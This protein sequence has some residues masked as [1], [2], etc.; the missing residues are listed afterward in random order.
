MLIMGVM[1]MNEKERFRKAIFEMVKQ[2]KLALI[3]ASIQCGLSYRQVLANLVNQ[4]GQQNV[5]LTF[6]KPNDPN[7]LKVKAAQIGLGLMIMR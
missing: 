5:Y 7:L 4:F 3:Q 6:T 2:K 1:V